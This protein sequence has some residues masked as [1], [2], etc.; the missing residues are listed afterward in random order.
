MAK[1]EA[2]TCPKEELLRRLQRE[3]TCSSCCSALRVMIQR[4]LTQLSLLEAFVSHEDSLGYVLKESLASPKPLEVRPPPRAPSA[5]PAP[6]AR[7][8][9]APRSGGR[10]AG[11]GC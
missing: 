4:P 2:I 5:A 10:A 3:T 6:R 1:S 9:G 11:W 8:P 7:R